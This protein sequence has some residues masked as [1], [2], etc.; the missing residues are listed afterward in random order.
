MDAAG[1][2]EDCPSPNVH[3]Y[4]SSPTDVL[5]MV[6]RAGEHTSEGEKLK[7]DLR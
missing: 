7:L 5:L 1:E 2:V 6:T 3:E 4:E